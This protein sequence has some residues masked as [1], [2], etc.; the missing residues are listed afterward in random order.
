LTVLRVLRSLGS[1]SDDGEN[2]THSSLESRGGSLHPDVEAL[3]S[4]VDYVVSVLR[5][6]QCVRIPII[7]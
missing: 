6:A 7:M 5:S 2:T 1:M 4:D 3:R